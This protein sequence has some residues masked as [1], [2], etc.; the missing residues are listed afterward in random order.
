MIPR[1]LLRPLLLGTVILL[2]LVALAGLSILVRAAPRAVS[3]RITTPVDGGSYIFGE[4]ILFHAVDD[5]GECIPSPYDIVW[6]FWPPGALDPIEYQFAPERM[7]GAT[8]QNRLLPLPGEYEVK[9]KMCNVESP[10]VGFQVEYQSPPITDQIHPKFGGDNDLC[11][12]DWNDLDDDFNHLTTAHFNVYWNTTGQDC[13]DPPNPVATRIPSST[14]LG[15]MECTYAWLDR[16]MT[17]PLDDLSIFRHYDGYEDLTHLTF[18]MGKRGGGGSSQPQ[19]VGFGVGVNGRIMAHELFH[20]FDYA[21]NPLHNKRLDRRYSGNAYHFYH[22]GPARIEQT[23]SPD[24]FTLWGYRTDL[25]PLWTPLDLGLLELDYDAGPF[26]SYLINNFGDDFSPASPRESW[27]GPSFDACNQFVQWDGLDELRPHNFKLFEAWNGEVRNRIRDEMGPGF[28]LAEYFNECDGHQAPDLSFL[29]VGQLAPVCSQ[30]L[31]FEMTVLQELVTGLVAEEGTPLEESLLLDFAVQFAQA[32]PPQSLLTGMPEV[33]A[34][35]DR[36]GIT[37]ASGFDGLPPGCPV[38]PEPPPDV[39]DAP[40][41]PELIAANEHDFYARIQ[42]RILEPEAHYLWLQANDDA[43]LYVDGLAVIGE[44]V[45]GDGS[46]ED[47]P[48]ASTTYA[49]QRYQWPENHAPVSSIFPIGDPTGKLFEIEWV[50]RG[51]SRGNSDWRCSPDDDR[52]LLTLEWSNEPVTT[53]FTRLEDD[54]VQIVSAQFWPNQGSGYPGFDPPVE[55]DDYADPITREVQLR[56]VAWLQRPFLLPALGVHYHPV[57]CPAGYD[58][59]LEVVIREDLTV[60]THNHAVAHLLAIED[61]QTVDWRGELEHPDDTIWRIFLDCD[62]AGGPARSD[63][64]PAF[65][66]VTSRLTTH[67]EEPGSPATMGA[68]H[69]TVIVKPTS[70]YHLHLPL[71]LKLWQSG[72][73]TSTPTSAP[74]SSPTP[75]ATPTNTLTP[76]PTTTPTPTPTPTNTPTPTPTPSNTPTPTTVILTPIADAYISVAAPDTNYGTAPTLYVGKSETSIRRSLFQFDLSSIPAGATV[77]SATFQ[78][79]LVAFSATPPLLDV[80]LKRVDDSWTELGVTWNSQPGTTSIGKVNGVGV[81]MSYYDWDAA[82]LVQDWV[83]GTANHGL[84]LWSHIEAIYGWRGFASRESPSPP[85]PPQLVIT[86]Q[87]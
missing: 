2:A 20:T 32:F 50:N 33:V 59:D 78:A 55:W 45:P 60:L 8:G 41:C 79:Y 13:K 19:G 54:Q 4:P 61:L 74:T 64:D 46:T 21:G 14:E 42:F 72:G 17:S 65:I 56:S 18:W 22:E 85:Y 81:E 39:D 71:I 11:W 27:Q 26:W 70:V 76:T 10:V 15:L 62:G 80:E 69:Y 1:V 6:S 83:D 16:W 43:T 37:F 53:T 73:P 49:D 48:N 58:G 63:D 38:D 24:A 9:A 87:P 66:L 51:D 44:A 31:E 23:V 57:Q 35:N 28:E 29:Y 67:D 84:A 34:C 86:Y 36:P 77:I 5:A 7:L 40:V 52:Y 3:P 75:T 47:F 82:E 25:W 30:T 68:V 12:I